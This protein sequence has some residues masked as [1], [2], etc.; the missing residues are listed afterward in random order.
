MKR[1]AHIEYSGFKRLCFTK[2]SAFTHSARTKPQCYHEQIDWVLTSCNKQGEILSWDINATAQVSA[3][4][5]ATH[6]TSLEIN[7]HILQ[8]IGMKWMLPRKC[9]GQRPSR[10][11]RPS[12]H[13]TKVDST[14]L[15]NYLNIYETLMQGPNSEPRWALMNWACLHRGKV[16]KPCN[17]LNSRGRFLGGRKPGHVFMREIYQTL[18]CYKINR[19]QSCESIMLERTYINENQ[20]NLN[21]T[22]FDEKVSSNSYKMRPIKL[23]ESQGWIHHEQVRTKLGLPEM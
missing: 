16:D 21:C 7:P 2:P 23:R 17:V 5:G 22:S 11:E 4:A 8:R 15:A 13:S 19:K 3:S 12:M 14:I 1:V 20:P 10:A 9:L 6:I 18:Q